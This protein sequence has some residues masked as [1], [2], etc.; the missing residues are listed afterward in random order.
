MDGG[1]ISLELRVWKTTM[2]CEHILTINM[3]HGC[4]EVIND[5]YAL[6]FV[7]QEMLSGHN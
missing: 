4:I 3:A 7:N 2:L 6:F 5:H 1:E